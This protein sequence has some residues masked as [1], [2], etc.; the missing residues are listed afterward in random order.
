ML[1]SLYFIS[2]KIHKDRLPKLHRH[3]AV[4]KPTKLSIQ[5][6]TNV[7]CSWH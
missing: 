5:M 2:Q 1:P 4:L 6:K 3:D 7:L